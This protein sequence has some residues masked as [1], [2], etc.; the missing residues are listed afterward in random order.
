[1]SKEG[2]SQVE[3]HWKSFTLRVRHEETDAQKKIKMLNM[4]F[5]CSYAPL[6][7]TWVFNQCELTMTWKRCHVHVVVPALSPAEPLNFC[8][9]NETKTGIKLKKKTPHSFTLFK[10]I[11]NTYRGENCD[12]SRCRVKKRS[13]R[14]TEENNEKRGSFLWHCCPSSRCCVDLS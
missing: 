1:M 8:I 3:F 7:V 2:I 6:D 4:D 12:V 9:S 11:R 13:Q 5:V 14:E 10:V